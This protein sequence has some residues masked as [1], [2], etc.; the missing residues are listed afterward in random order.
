MGKD[1][2][3]FVDELIELRPDQMKLIEDEVDRQ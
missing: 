3:S 1:L 2:R